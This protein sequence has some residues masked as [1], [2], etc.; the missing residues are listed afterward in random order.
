VVKN[1]LPRKKARTFIQAEGIHRP[2]E[3][4]ADR[5][6]NVPPSQKQPVKGAGRMGNEKKTNEPADKGGN[7]GANKLKFAVVLLTKLPGVTVCYGCTS[8]FAFKYRSSPN[9]VILRT[10]CNR[11]YRDKQGVEKASNKITAAYC[12]LK[13][14]CVRKIQPATEVR[15]DM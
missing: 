1:I 14:E 4:E 15:N 7:K 12:H 10:F 5:L 6:G 2:V 13:M 11:R 9:D 8:K 3:T